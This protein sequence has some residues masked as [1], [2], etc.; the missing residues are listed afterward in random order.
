MTG[1]GARRVLAIVAGVA[2]ASAF[3]AW[4]WHRTAV[5]HRA[6]AKANQLSATSAASPTSSIAVDNPTA[7]SADLK[8]PAAPTVEFIARDPAAAAQA[9]QSRAWNALYARNRKE[10][11]EDVA[12]LMQL[13]YNEAWDKLLASAKG[14]DIGAGAAAMQIESICKAESTRVVRPN[15]K[16]LPA[17][18]YYKDLPD[19]WKPFVDRLGELHDEDHRRITQCEGVGDAFD[20]ATLFFDRFFTADNPE[21]Q[22]EVAGSNRDHMQAIADLREILAAHDVPRGRAGLGDLLMRSD[23]AAERAE[24]RAMLEALAPDNPYVATSLAYC[25]EHG[26]GGAKPD[27]EAARPWLEQADGVGDELALSYLIESLKQNGDRA[28]AWAW[29]HYALDLALDGCFEAF[30]PMYM[31]IA[32]RASDEAKTKAVL[33]PAEQNAGL[34]IGYAIS[35]RW[36]KQ[37][38]ERLACE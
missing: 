34:A 10:F 21:A 18:A 38:R 26:C 7:T 1:I 12:R 13:P 16:V 11:G 14:G 28:A 5:A 22:V 6:L 9:W 30:V 27:P 33:T 29:A 24:G 23:D 15:A 8:R 32:G 36:E 31:E 2:L 17:S 19:A 35:G 25:L 3:V 4:H 20:L 37:A